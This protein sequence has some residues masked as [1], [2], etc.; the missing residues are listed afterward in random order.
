M[1]KNNIIITAVI[2]VIVAAGSFFGGYKYS[3]SKLATRTGARNMTGQFGGANA[4]GTRG[5]F[6]PVVGDVLSA[7]SK[8]LTVKQTDGSSRVVILSTAT[9]INQAASASA[10]D[11]KA[12]SK[13]AVYG[14]TNTDGSVTAQS[15]QINPVIS[16]AS[17]MMGR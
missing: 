9:Q 5:A 16:G 7:D 3:Q 11:I 17:G 12:G 15:V 14:T 4:A 2:A 6:R 13:V 1:S 10:S 8:S